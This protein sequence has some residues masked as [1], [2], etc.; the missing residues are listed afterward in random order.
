M[1]VASWPTPR[2]HAAM[3]VSRILPF[4]MLGMLL[5]GMAHAGKMVRVVTWNVETIGSPNSGEF[6]AA[7]AVLGRVDADVV[8]L[9]EIGSDQDAEYVTQ[10]AFDLGYPYTFVTP[11]GPFGSDRSAILSD[12]PLSL[13]QYWTAA[14]LSEDPLANDLTRYLTEVVIDTGQGED[15]RVI[16]THL[17]SGAS[18]VDEFRRAIESLRLNQLATDPASADLPVVIMGDLN[19]DV[20]DDPLTPDVFLT[21]PTDLPS[22]F[23]VGADVHALLA[24]TGLINDP[25]YYLNTNTVILEALQL[26][27]SEATRPTSGRRLDYVLISSTLDVP[28]T[29]AQVYDCADEGLLGGLPLTGSPLAAAVCPAAADHLPVFADLHLTLKFF[30]DVPV[31]SWAH[32]YIHAIRDAGITT[33]CGNNNYCPQGLVTRDQMAAF[34]IRAIEGDPQG[35]LCE[36][37][38]PYSDI[39]SGAWYCSHV[40]RLVDLAITG[41]CG[42]GKYCPSNKVTREQMAAFIVRAVAGEPSPNYCGGVAPFLDVPGNAWSC[43]YIKKLVELGIT[44]GCGNGNYCPDTEVTREQMAAF[45]ARAFLLVM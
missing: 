45:L 38:S 34:L 4:T 42:E 25:F 21:V 5:M 7:S 18:N 30:N 22:S 40:A 44:Q 9:Q 8:A 35:N 24:G 2:G 19:A 36:S 11:G 39:S 13:S 20:N 37:G 33:G 31:G 6:Q 15:L 16:V 41:G 28:D 27:G 26:D 32:G 29:K 12:Y 3:R 10:L 1:R 14:Q 43:A 17:K 23:V